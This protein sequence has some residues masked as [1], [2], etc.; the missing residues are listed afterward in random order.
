MDL[1]RRS[2]SFFRKRYLEILENLPPLLR[3]GGHDIPDPALAD[4]GI[5]VPAQP[6]VHEQHL[7]VLEPDGG[8]VEQVLA[9]PRTVI[10]AGDLHVVGVEIQPPGGVVDHQRHLGEADAPAVGG[11]AENDVLHL[12]APQAFGGLFPQHPADGVAYVGFS[13]AVGTHH[14]GNSPAEGQDRLVWKRLKTVDLQCLQQHT[15]H[16]LFA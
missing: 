9:V 6:C 13:A 4:D 15:A 14:R 10:P 1:S 16:L 3:F 11:A 5:A 8:V 2:A 12:G 7:H